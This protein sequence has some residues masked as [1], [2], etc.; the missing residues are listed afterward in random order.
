[1]VLTPAPRPQ[2]VFFMSLCCKTTTFKDAKELSTMFKLKR[3]VE[4]ILQA[5]LWGSPSGQMKHLRPCALSPSPAH[6]SCPM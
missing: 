3:I 4:G 5:P 1:M 6:L 2:D